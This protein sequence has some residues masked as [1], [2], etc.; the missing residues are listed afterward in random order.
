MSRVLVIS[1]AGFVGRAVAAALRRRKH[2][3]VTAS[4]RATD[5]SGEL[6]CDVTNAGQVERTIR[7]VAPAAVAVCCGAPHDGPAA[8]LYAVHALGTLHV[9]EAVRRHAAAAP[10]VLIG[11]AAEYGPTEPRQLPVREDHPCRPAGVY[12]CS[13]LA[14]A[15]LA[16]FAQESWGLRVRTARL[17]NAVGPGMPQRYFFPALAARLRGLA[18]GGTFPLRD[19]DSTRDFIHVDDVGEAVAFLADTSVPD[20]VYNVATGLE[21]SVREAAEYLGELAGRLTPVDDGTAAPPNRSV[22]DAARL[23]SLG[24]TPRRTW[25]QA[26][27][28]IWSQP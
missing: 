25:R 2:D 23:R 6:A 17:F 13:K 11:S 14:Q 27:A 9:L 20:G 19:G 10:V 22:G 24:W 4:R 5:G 7:D 21:T 16:R 8:D 26:I 1:A 28:D 12:G 3:L 15:D 18:A